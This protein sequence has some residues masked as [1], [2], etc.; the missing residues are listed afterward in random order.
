MGRINNYL[1]VLRIVSLSGVMLLTGGR[2]MAQSVSP[3]M[4]SPNR[5][6]KAPAP[7]RPAPPQQ[8]PAKQLPGTRAPQ[9]ILKASGDGVIVGYIWWDA[10]TINHVPAKNCSGLSITVSA[11]TSSQSSPTL[12]QFMPLGTYTNNLTYIPNVGADG[13]CQFAVHQMPVGQ[14][15]QVRL[16]VS[17]PTAFSPISAPAIA[18][19]PIKI[20]GGKCNNLPPA[21]PSASVL[22]NNWWTCGNSAYNVN[23]A[24]KPSAHILSSG[25]G[26]GTM[27]VSSATKQ[28]M[29]SNSTQ[30]GM[31]AGGPAQTGSQ[32]PAPGALLGNRQAAT[33]QSGGAQNRPNQVELNPQPHPPAQRLTNAD[34]IK[35][36]QSRVPESVIVSSART[37]RGNFDLSPSGC[38]ALRQAHVSEQVLSAMAD[39]SAR[40]CAAAAASPDRARL[41]A[42]SLKLTSGRQIKL[43]P[44][45]ST[46]ADA[47]L[48]Q[49]FQ[50]QSI[51]THKEKIS[52]SVVDRANAGATANP[53]LV[54]STARTSLVAPS[55]PSQIG[56]SHTMGSGTDPVTGATDP[57]S[58]P[59]STPPA[60]SQPGSTP[61]GGTPLQ[62]AG[63]P[64]QQAGNP[65]AQNSISLMQRATKATQP[66]SM[67]RFSTDPVIETVS[68]RQHGIVLTPDPGAGQYPNNQYTIRGCNFGSIQGQVQIYGAFI[69]NPSP[70]QLGIDSWNDNQVLVTFNPTFQNEYDLNNITLA[71]VRTDGHNTKIPGISFYATRVSRSLVRVPQS[72]VKLPTTSLTR[73]NFVSPVN[74]ATLQSFG[75]T[76]PL[77][78]ASAVFFIYDPIWTSNAGDG[79][80][81]T[82]LSFSDSVD[83]SQLHAGFTLDAN[84]QTLVGPY[85]PDLSSRSG[86][87]VDGG[88]CKY[89]D[90]VV[91]ANMQGKNLLVGVQPA[92]CDNS[93]KFI[94]AYYGL[95]L[96]VTGPKGDLLD[97]W[98]SGLQ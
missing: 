25:S 57:A 13:V 90:V 41:L 34:L 24:L 70:V 88:S 20:T 75:L 72:V 73:N 79:Y 54:A 42:Q 85:S 48:T 27:S 64:P 22:S 19:T 97:A 29:L 2:L 9:P 10:N 33:G 6:I 86:F 62:Q 56:P 47:S 36:V 30:R 66:I 80:P 38:S 15:L 65:P 14:S 89:S 51:A 82:R 92:E 44:S 23:F 49:T 94:Y 81:P 84:M 63:D 96:S 68:G 74:G 17:S 11:G 16:D 93:G 37:S 58:D 3:A 43:A 78:P 45:A 50:A 12:E 95:Q 59:G 91:G 1:R 83:F 32:A 8:Q 35:M 71:V 67:C 46:G 21:V 55:V 4:P 26:A 61:G 77:Q 7:Q 52:P 28:E 18:I 53:R 39:G 87:G 5:N 76:A 60:G 69:N 98:P 40:P 31:L